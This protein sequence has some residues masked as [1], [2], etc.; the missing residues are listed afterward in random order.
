MRTSSDHTSVVCLLHGLDF[1]HYDPQ[2]PS[3]GFW[4]LVQTCA[5]SQRDSSSAPREYG[6]PG[7]LDTTLCQTNM[8]HETRVLYRLLSSFKTFWECR[9]C[10]EG[11]SYVALLCLWVLKLG[12]MAES[13]PTAPSRM[14]LFLQDRSEAPL[15]SHC[16]LR[17]L[18][19]F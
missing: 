7:D 16:P 11:S 3:H 17:L 15:K 6:G 19:T 4:S 9:G 12:W 2:K 13:L 10:S 14:L 18:D 5:V 8:E 1:G